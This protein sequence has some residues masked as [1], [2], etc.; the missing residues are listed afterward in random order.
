MLVVILLIPDRQPDIGGHT[1]PIRLR[2]GVGCMAA[3][4]VVKPTKGGIDEII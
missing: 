4:V 1:I 3:D 2:K